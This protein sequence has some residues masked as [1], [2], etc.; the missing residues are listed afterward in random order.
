MAEFGHRIRHIREDSYNQTLPEP[1]EIW[2]G[3]TGSGDIFNLHIGGN[4]ANDCASSC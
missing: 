1:W 3:L 4:E 2:Q